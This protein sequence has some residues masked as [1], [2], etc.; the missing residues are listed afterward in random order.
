MGLCCVALRISRGVSN[1][2]DLRVPQ[3]RIRDGLEGLYVVMMRRY[4]LVG[5]TWYPHYR[6]MFNWEV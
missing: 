1:E 4:D 6:S 3:P 2:S 5:R